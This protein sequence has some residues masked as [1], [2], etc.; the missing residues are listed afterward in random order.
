MLHAHG[1]STGREISRALLARAHKIPHLHLR[2]HAFTTEMIV[3]QGRVTGLRFIDETDGSEHD[4]RT[5]AVLLAT[6]GLGQIYRETTNPEVATGHVL[7]TPHTP[8]A[9]PS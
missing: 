4:L 5:G 2:A 6:G 7:A 1:D 9:F 3:E 8:N